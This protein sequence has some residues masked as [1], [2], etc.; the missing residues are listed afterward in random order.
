MNRIG[1]D[2][3]GT[4]IEGVVLDP[5]G[6]EPARLRIETPRGDYEATLRAI[7]KLVTDLEG[8]AG[9]VAA[10]IGIGTPGSISGGTL[11]NSNAVYL[12][13]KPL[14]ADLERALGREV[15]LRNDADCFALSEAADGAGAS[16]RVIFGV[17]IGTGVGGGVVVDRRALD[18]PNG[19]AGEWGHNPLPWPRPDELPGPSCYC[20]LHGCI[21][22]FLSGTGFASLSGA[23]SAKEVVEAS[24]RDDP[25]ASAHLADY[26][27]R[28]ARGLAT[29]INVLDP[30]A[31]VLGGGMSNVD[32]IYTQTPSRWDRYVFSE[33]VQTPL[34]KNRH[35]D[36]SGVRGAAWLVGI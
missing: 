17:I 28:L 5:L 1:I 20:G 7:G 6:A 22:T 16:Y 11:R 34:L 29:I 26:C 18:G 27:D 21:E 10:A 4:K 8:K 19:V 35:G 23:A 36:S 33:R 31:I 30:D 9:P 12:N 15:V 2:L 32:E 13:G 25:E 24:R 14:H 3:G